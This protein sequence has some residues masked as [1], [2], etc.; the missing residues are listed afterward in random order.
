M[1]KWGYDL[2]VSTN[3][4]NLSL[5][6]YLSKHLLIPKHLIF[7]LRKDHRVTVNNKYIPMNFTVKDGDQLRIVFIESDF[8]LPVQNILPDNHKII[9]ILF[10]NEDILVVNKMAGIKTHPNQPNES[11]TLLNFCE[12]YLNKENKHAYMIHRLDQETSGA[13]IVGKNPAVVPILVRL[14]KDKIIHRTYLTWVEGI[15]QN[16]SDNINLPIGFDQNDKRKRK[17]NGTSSQKALTRYEVLKERNNCSLVEVQL[18]T[19]RTHQIRVHMKAMNHPI[20]GDPLYNPESISPKML[21]HSWK[22]KLI[23]P[24]YMITKVLESPVNDYFKNM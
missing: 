19:G 20:I 6:E 12:N 5:R 24:Y 21:L 22:L 7:S 11:G 2:K 10:E 13:I 4:K 1:K 16:K 14:I 17:I 15:F 23:F 18:Q 3:I 9:N 8:H